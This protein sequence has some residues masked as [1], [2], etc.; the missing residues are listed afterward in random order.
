M[1]ARMNACDL[2]VKTNHYLIQGGSLTEPQTN[3]IVRQLLSAQ[4]SESQATRFHA[5]VGC[6]GNI[7]RQGHRMH[8]TLY[9][10]PYQDGRKLKTI[11]GQ[12][13][14]TQLLSANMYELEIVR[15][16]ALLAPQHPAVPGMVAD[17]L[18]RLRTTC[19][20][21]K[22]NGVGECFDASL[23]VLRFLATAAPT[24]HKWILE[25]IE[26]YNRHKAEK[27]RPWHATWYFW[28]CLSELPYD[29]V[30]QEIDG[31]LPEIMSWLTTKSATM[32]SDTDRTIHP[33]LLCMLRNLVAN[34]PEYAHIRSMQPHISERDGRLYLHIDQPSPRMMD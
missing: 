33:V 11:F 4:S 7:D 25:R 22:D 24:D 3:T 12:T 26:N 19:F 27:K 29:L 30:K 6:P 13:P 23:I 16:L 5:G 32:N 15:L 18:A 8:P 10:P 21:N 20:G 2:M 14:T 34:M 17:V 31:Y 1:V 9:I 28:L